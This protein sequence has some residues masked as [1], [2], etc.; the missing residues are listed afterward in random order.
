MLF[1]VAGDYAFDIDEALYDYA[2]HSHD[3]INTLMMAPDTLRERMT[4]VATRLGE[5][6]LMPKVQRELL[7]MLQ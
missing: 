4:H 7:L 2:Y 1:S 6:K 5:L 3:N